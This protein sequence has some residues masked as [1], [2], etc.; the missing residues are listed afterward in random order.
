M[1]CPFGDPFCPCTRLSFECLR[2]VS[3][4]NIVISLRQLV[5][6]H[7]GSEEEADTGV[8]TVPC[9]VLKD[10]REVSDWHRHH[11]DAQKIRETIEAHDATMRGLPHQLLLDFRRLPV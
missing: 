4:T 11:P 6:L 9:T 7:D 1:V 10:L 3:F 5:F 8:P 2:C